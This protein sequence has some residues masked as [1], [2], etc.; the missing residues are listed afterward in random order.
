M[1]HDDEFL[2]Q[3]AAEAGEHWL[4]PIDRRKLS[5]ARENARL[6]QRRFEKLCAEVLDIKPESF[7]RTMRRREL[8]D[9]DLPAS[10]TTPQYVIAI[11]TTIY[12]GTHRRP[13][14]D[15]ALKKIIRSIVLSAPVSLPPHK[16]EVVLD[17]TGPVDL[18]QE[19][20]W[21]PQ[22]R[23][24][25]C[26]LRRD[27]EVIVTGDGDGSVTRDSPA[28]GNA[29]RDGN[30]TGDAIRDGAG[31]GYAVRQGAGAG[32]AI[33][34]GK[35]MGSACRV[36]TGRGDAR[37]EGAGYGWAIHTSCGGGEAINESDG[38]G[39]RVYLGGGGGRQVGGRINRRTG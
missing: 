5:V 21:D 12:R 38:G 14:S 13:P 1:R 32:D 30:G 18:P 4:I 9:Q 22:S 16:L 25:T 3:L 35:G 34:R 24:V 17:A 8:E 26:T 28:A 33:R 37:R 6:S 19:L 2:N 31:A 29:I 23:M 20:H 39:G 7:S 11:A 15:D 36:G 27:C 10:R